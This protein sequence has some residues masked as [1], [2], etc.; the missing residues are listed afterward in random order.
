MEKC[1]CSVREKSGRHGRMTYLPRQDY[2]LTFTATTGRMPELRYGGGVKTIS[3]EELYALRENVFVFITVAGKYQDAIK[4]QLA[5]NGIANIFSIEMASLS[6]FMDD[7]MGEGSPEK[8]EQYKCVTDDAEYLKA[9]ARNSLGYELNLENPRTFNEKL[10]WLKL[11]YRKTEFSDMVD[12][13]SVK[14]YASK[15]IGND[16]IIPTLGVY[17]SFDEIDFEKLP[18]Q[19]VLKCTHDSSSVIVCKNK[20]NFDFDSARKKLSSSLKV[21]YYW[22]AREWPYKNVKPRVIADM[23]LDDHT[24]NELRDYKFWCFDGKPLYM[25]CSVKNNNCYENFYDMEFNP[26]YIDHSFP[27][28]NPEFQKPEAFEKMKELAEKLSLGIPVVRIDFFEVEDR[29]YF[30][31]YTFYDWAGL[32]SFGSDWDRKLGELIKLPDC[33]PSEK[34]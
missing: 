31:E 1:A 33:L 9:Y 29:V 14:E 30:A 7:I 17:D 24:G 12:K 22:V 34:L 26:I 11:N 16:Y 10:N 28:H 18:K 6:Y 4:E 8:I 15:L 21:N 13:Y 32:R 2:T 27:R 5:E 25:Y 3:K 20:L 23:Y 19:F